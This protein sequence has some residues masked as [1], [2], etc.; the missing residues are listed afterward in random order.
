MVATHGCIINALVSKENPERSSCAPPANDDNSYIIMYSE[1]NIYNV[2]I[3]YIK[4][5]VFVATFPCCDIYALPFHALNFYAICERFLQYISLVHKITLFLVAVNIFVL[6][7]H[8]R[9]LGMQ[10][11]CFSCEHFHAL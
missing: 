2:K 3:A 7:E 4:N 6:C 1:T 5:Y 10:Y 8:F 11:S 9:Q